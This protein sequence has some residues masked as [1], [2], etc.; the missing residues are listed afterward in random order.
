IEPRPALNSGY[1]YA[2]IGT[3]LYSVSKTFDGGDRM[4]R[5]AVDG[6]TDSVHVAQIVNVPAVDIKKIV[7]KMIDWVHRYK[8][9]E[10]DLDRDI[11]L[12]LGID[13]LES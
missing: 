2:G 4:G 1:F 6:I 11:C 12:S 5:P 10:K 13:L 9:L 3:L 7:V 8:N